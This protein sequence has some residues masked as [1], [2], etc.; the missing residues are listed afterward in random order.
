MSRPKLIQKLA[1]LNPELTKIE[2]QEI[3]DCFSDALQKALSDGKNIELRGFGTFLLK[4][5]KERYSA[6]NP[7]TGKL[8]YI[9][10][11]NKVRFRASK[12]FKDYIN[13]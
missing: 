13:K 9:P 10:E 8:V 6:R 11:K 1:K 7:K 5:T 4:K 2:I 3:I 12:K